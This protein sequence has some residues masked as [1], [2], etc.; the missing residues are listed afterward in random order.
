MNKN[1]IT[2]KE[3]NSSIKLNLENQIKLYKAQGSECLLQSF[4]VDVVKCLNNY[5][6]VLTRIEYYRLKRNLTHIFEPEV[7]LDQIF[8]VISNNNLS[9]GFA[10]LEEFVLYV[11]KML[12]YYL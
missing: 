1:E 6:Y 11:I 9:K 4:Y 3:V 2:I 5:L 10:P 12:L 8:S 7:S